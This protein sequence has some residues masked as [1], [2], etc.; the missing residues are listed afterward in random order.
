MLYSRTTHMATVR[1]KV[2]ISSLALFCAMISLVNVC[3]MSVHGACKRPNNLSFGS[4]I[5]SA[6]DWQSE[7]CGLDA[8]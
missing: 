1:G 8:C 4:T 2:L 5:G 3:T 7:G 6:L